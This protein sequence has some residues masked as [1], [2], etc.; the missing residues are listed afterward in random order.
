MAFQKKKK[1]K[2]FLQTRCFRFGG[3]PPIC[4]SRH[5]HRHQFKPV[6]QP[7]Y[8]YQLPHSVRRHRFTRSR[9]LSL[10]RFGHRYT[11]ASSD[12]RDRHHHWFGI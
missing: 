6:T 11:A 9:S 7:R 12:H 3:N 1:K 10:V 2:S 8:R 5:H 4:K